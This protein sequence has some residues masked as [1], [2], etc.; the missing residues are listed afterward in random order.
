[1]TGG[2]GGGFFFPAVD[3]G[4]AD[5]FEASLLVF[6]S[7][8]LVFGKLGGAGTVFPLSELADGGGGGC[9]RF[10]AGL[11]VGI[12]GKGFEGAS[13]NDGRLS[14][15]G[16]GGGFLPPGGGGG[17]LAFGGKPG[18]VLGD[19]GGGGGFG[20]TPAGVPPGLDFTLEGAEGVVGVD[21]TDGGLD[22]FSCRLVWAD[23]M[24]GF[25]EDSKSA[26]VFNFLVG[27]GGVASALLLLAMEEASSAS[28]CPLSVVD[29]FASSRLWVLAAGGRESEMD[30]EWG[31]DFGGGGFVKRASP[32]SK[33]DEYESW[34]GDPC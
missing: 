28:V 22:S 26:S 3:E 11:L 19:M 1:M 33:L 7:S 21:G 29:I 25:G 5:A 2:G 10:D 14:S 20:D 16:G 23:F 6:S 8:L 15:E 31:G 34:G 9:P 27:G 18:V 4:G 13:W 24:N 12:F 17:G 32:S 30:V